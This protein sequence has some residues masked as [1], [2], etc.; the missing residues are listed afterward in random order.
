MVISKV[1]NPEA[2]LDTCEE[3]R[4]AAFTASH[5]C[6][7]MHLAQL[8]VGPS[9]VVLP[10]RLLEFTGSG[11]NAWTAAEGALK[12]RE[13]SYLACAGGNAEQFLH[14]PSVALGRSD[15]LVVLDG[16]GPNGAILLHR[17]R[18]EDRPFVKEAR[19]PLRF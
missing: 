14:V 8:E 19:S 6:A 9:G 16:G 4:S 15:T 10:S 5:L 13:T 11:I 3:E 7:L 17:R 1:G 18:L 2:D 12:T